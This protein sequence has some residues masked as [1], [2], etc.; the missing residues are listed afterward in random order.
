MTNEDNVEELRKYRAWLATLPKAE[1]V[2]M[3]TENGGRTGVWAYTIEGRTGKFVVW[4]DAWLNDRKVVARTGDNTPM[5]FAMI[6]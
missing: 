3:H 1:V 2:G 4:T 6:L 5:A